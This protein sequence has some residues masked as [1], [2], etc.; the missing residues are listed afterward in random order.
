MGNWQISSQFGCSREPA[1]LFSQRLQQAEFCDI[2]LRNIAKSL[3][4]RINA[5]YFYLNSYI[6]KNLV[7]FRGIFNFIL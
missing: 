4:M 1:N 5:N 3:K 6:N 2:N 7:K